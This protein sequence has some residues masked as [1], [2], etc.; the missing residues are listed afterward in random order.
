VQ[1]ADAV[2]A[3]P[4]LKLRKALGSIGEGGIV[5]SACLS[6]Q[7]C[8]EAQLGQINPEYVHHDLQYRR[9]ATDAC[10]GLTLFA[11]PWQC[12]GSRSYTVSVNTRAGSSCRSLLRSRGR[13]TFTT[14]DAPESEL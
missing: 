7:G 10:S 1:R 12:A 13:G 3:K 11:R 14:S 9:L 2:V 8:V 5:L 6:E 4:G